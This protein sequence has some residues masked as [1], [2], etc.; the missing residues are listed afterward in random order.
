MATPSTQI[1]DQSPF[2]SSSSNPIEM[3]GNITTSSPVHDGS[4]LD[5]PVLVTI[6]RDL[7]AVLR[8]FGHA[9]VPRETQTLL[10]DWDL[11]GPLM[12]STVLAV[13]LQSNPTKSSSGVQ[14][15][16]VFSLMAIGYCLL[17]LLLAG[18]INNVLLF[19]PVKSFVILLVRFII[20]FVAFS[21]TIYASMKFLG[22][23]QRPNRK[24]LV[25]YPVFLFYFVI[26]WF[27]LLHAHP[28]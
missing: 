9:L 14:F 1:V 27:I 11:W 21:W 15:A 3:Q 5:E 23:T 16:E 4:T 22:T 13:L 20:V 18:C 7:S 24:P 17:P 8:K 12:L 6:K 10:K 19:L 28:A 26:A 25:M 2:L